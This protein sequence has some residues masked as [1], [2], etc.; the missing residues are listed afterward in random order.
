MQD[1]HLTISAFSLIA[2]CD[3]RTVRR[4]VIA[5]AIQPIGKSGPYDVYDAA[6]LRRIM[7]D[8][9]RPARS[10]R[11][12]EIIIAF[13]SAY[14]GAVNA[15]GNSLPQSLARA[16]SESGIAATPTQADRAALSLWESLCK[17]I[18]SGLDSE[19]T[20]LTGGEHALTGDDSMTSETIKR[21]VVTDYPE[22]LQPIVSRVSLANPA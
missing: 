7:S 20:S 16:L 4:R 17:G 2:E 6:D 15:I 18:E 10:R 14:S 12:Q 11:S 5:N 19:Y 9:V 3:P 13:E 21:G 22:G 8:R 1:K